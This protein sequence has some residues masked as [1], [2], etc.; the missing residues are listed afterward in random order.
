MVQ[1]SE[2]DTMQIQSIGAYSAY[3]A[4]QNLSAATCGCG[5]EAR[6][7]AVS[8][9]ASRTDQVTLSAWSI[10]LSQETTALFQLN[11]DLSSSA[12]E[13]QESLSPREQIDEMA[14]L[15]RQLKDEG[16]I[17]GR[18]ARHLLK[19]L[20]LASKALEHG[21]GLP[22]ARFLGHVARVV[23]KLADHG[24]MPDD[25]ANQLIDSTRSIVQQLRDDASWP[26]RNDM[27]NRA[28]ILLIKSEFRLT[29]TQATFTQETTE[30]E[31]ND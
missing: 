8:T 15:V 2:G 27:S 26:I 4:L 28:G 10:T 16:K 31:L 6:E 22:A 20:E 12:E 21:R 11:G 19:T 18:R 7:N 25:A 30:V 29:I 9:L 23:D 5:D 3:K 17:S 1:A 14:D 13:T 24:K